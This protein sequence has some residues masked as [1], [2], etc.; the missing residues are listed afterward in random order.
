[1]EASNRPDDGDIP[2]VEMVAMQ[3]QISL[4]LPDSYPPTLLKRSSN[5]TT[6]EIAER[7]HSKISKPKRKPTLMNNILSP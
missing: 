7:R 4:N 1:M 5:S 6:K 2:Y 3:Y